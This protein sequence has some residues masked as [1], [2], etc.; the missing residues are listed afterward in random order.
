MINDTEHHTIDSTSAITHTAISLSPSDEKE[1]R[2][3]IDIQ[4]K[5]KTKETGSS[6]VKRNYF[7]SNKSEIS[8][9]YFSYLSV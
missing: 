3:I 6:L 9:S 2:R 7:Y 4:C 5:I 8:F 1:N